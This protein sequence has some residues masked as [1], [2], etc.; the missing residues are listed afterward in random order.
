MHID[1]TADLCVLENIH[2]LYQQSVRHFQIRRKLLHLR[3]AREP[4]KVRIEIVN[5]M[6]YFVERM[7]EVFLEFAVRAESVLFKKEGNA[8]AGI[9]EI[10]V[11]RPFLFGGVKHGQ[12][13]VVVKTRN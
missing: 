9:E 4:F 12:M 13:P 10:F 11:A 3:R 8:I 5:R 6:A 2:T 1:N 7:K